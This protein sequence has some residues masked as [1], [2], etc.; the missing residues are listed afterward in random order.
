MFIGINV[1]INY[2][3]LRVAGLK[4]MTRFLLFAGQLCLRIT[5]V[6]FGYALLHS[7]Y[8]LTY[9]RVRAPS[10][11]TRHVVAETIVINLRYT[12]AD[13]D[14][15]CATTT[16]LSFVRVVFFTRSVFPELCRRTR[17]SVANHSIAAFALNTP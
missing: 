12:F 15:K 1:I 2:M 16:T 17:N 6:L 3:Y 8:L 4:L 9:V 10:P 11:T 7:P 5:A 14:L 13:A